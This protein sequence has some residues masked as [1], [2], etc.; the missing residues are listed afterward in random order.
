MI[1]AFTTLHVIE[2]G[3]KRFAS[4]FFNCYFN[5]TITPSLDPFYISLSPKGVEEY[6]TK[7]VKVETNLELKS[8]ENEE[9]SLC[10]RPFFSIN[11]FN[12][13]QD[14]ILRKLVQF[15][16]Y[17]RLMGVR[18]FNFYELTIFPKVRKYLTKLRKLHVNVNLRKWNLPT[19]NNSELWDYGSLGALN[20][21]LYQN[22]GKK[23]VIFIDLDEF[24]VPQ[25][26][27]GNTNLKGLINVL[28]K[29][30]LVI[31]ITGFKIIE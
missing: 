17:Y 14:Q 10:V 20:D 27:Y 16:S 8:F 25:G 5:V 11:D 9:L 12:E 29:S 2:E 22:M 23:H 28:E 15:V 19:G 13:D 7:L 21:C 26:Q 1:S 3:I 4:C 31:L 30:R 18:E 6:P 24:I